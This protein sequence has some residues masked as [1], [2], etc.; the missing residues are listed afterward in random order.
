MKKITLTFIMP[1]LSLVLYAYDAKIDGIYYKLN[2]AEKTAK[3]T[4][5]YWLDTGDEPE[6]Y[7][8]V[9]IPSEVKYSNITFKVT[10][11]GKAA[12]SHCRGLTSV[13]IPNSVTSIDEMA[14]AC[15]S[16]L[17]SITIPNSVIYIG[18]SAFSGCI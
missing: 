5:L 17:T 2:Y 6:Y 1:L 10:S 11:I 13:T 15:C 14:F 4:Y 12:F 3:V 9:V 18:T 16:G 8:K 7:G